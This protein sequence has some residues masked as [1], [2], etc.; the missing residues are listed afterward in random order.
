[1]PSPSDE[2]RICAMVD[3]YIKKVSKYYARNLDRAEENW[4]KHYSAEPVD[5]ILELLGREDDYPSD[6]FVLY[7]DGHACAVESEI[8]YIYFLSVAAEDEEYVPEKALSGLLG[9]ID[10]FEK[11]ELKGS[12]FCGG[13]NDGADIKGNPKLQQ[14]FEMGAGV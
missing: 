2:K 14:A 1:M 12:L 7:A 3:S 10:C 9:W 13:V 6:S 4:D 5:Y 8:L 11:A